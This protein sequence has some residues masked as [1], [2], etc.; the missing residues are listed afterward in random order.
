MKYKF[1]GTEQDLIENGF[2]KL[3]SQYGRYSVDHN[4]VFVDKDTNVLLQMEFRGE[5]VMTSSWYQV[6]L[7]TSRIQDLIDKGL[8]VEVEE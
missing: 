4:A 6:E 5:T 2:E 7:E 8:V 1:I 3:F